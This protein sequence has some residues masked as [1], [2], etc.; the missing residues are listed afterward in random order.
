MAKYI[1]IALKDAER[2]NLPQYGYCG[3][4]GR[5][6]FRVDC[7]FCG[8]RRIKVYAWSLAGGGKRCPSC[9]ALFSWPGYA[10]RDRIPA[11]KGEVAK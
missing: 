8:E 3:E 9:G 1:Q 10:F 11:K 2:R 5:S 7:P 4:H 6:T